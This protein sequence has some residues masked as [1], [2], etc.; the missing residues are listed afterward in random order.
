MD[1][2]EY[3]RM[4]Q[5]EGDH[6]WYRGMADISRRILGQIRP[7]AKPWNILDA[8]CGTG[9]AMTTFLARHGN[10]TGI[11]IAQEALRYCRMRKAARLTRGTVLHLPF[12]GEGFD[13]VTSFDVLYEEHVSDDGAAVREFHRVLAPGG[14]L[15]LRLPAY[16][17]MRRSHDQ[18][19][20][21]RRRYTRGQAA[22]LLRKS[23]FLIEK[24][25]YANCLL[26]PA[27]VAYLWKE[28]IFPPAGIHSDLSIRFG[29][30]NG[31]LTAVLSAEGPL[32]TRWGLPF[33]LSIFALGRKPA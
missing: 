2:R 8:G 22:L 29:R 1:A 31:F 18:V 30:L 10:V 14:R 32:I 9:G 6:W 7:P 26:F 13:L 20:Q 5:L 21:T 16:E 11:D 15:L 12:G 3:D 24:I 33:G 27:A 25:S 28:K 4:F 19:V 17:W 23:G